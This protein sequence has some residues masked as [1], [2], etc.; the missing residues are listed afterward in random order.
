MP[1]SRADLCTWYI[2]FNLQKTFPSSLTKITT[3]KILKSYAVPIIINQN[4]PISHLIYTKWMYSSLLRFIL[5]KQS[6]NSDTLQNIYWEGLNR[7]WEMILSTLH[8][9]HRQFPL[10]SGYLMTTLIMSVCPIPNL[11]GHDGRKRTHSANKFLKDVLA[12]SVKCFPFD[13]WESSTEIM[14]HF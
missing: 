10:N 2:C 3:C 12:R 5:Y 1:N 4:L 8:R 13:K 11:P 7:G 9:A 6:A 14:F